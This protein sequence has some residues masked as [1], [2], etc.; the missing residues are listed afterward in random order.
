MKNKLFYGSFFS[1][2]PVLSLV[3]VYTAQVH[4]PEATIVGSW[5]EVSWKYE[6]MDK[7]TQTENSWMQE[8]D[9]RVK[10]EISGHLHIHKAEKWE[11][12]PDR[13]LLLGKANHDHK[14]LHWT[15]KGRGNVLE[16]EGADGE[17]ETY[18]IQQLTA[19]KMVLH[20]STDLQVR[21]IVEMVFTRIKD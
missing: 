3:L 10:R 13:K 14:T 15:M 18:L 2:L 6:K 5:Q 7:T 12:S 17:Q 9:D 1:L 11:F 20:F 16:L 21:G 8:M 19:E 4:G